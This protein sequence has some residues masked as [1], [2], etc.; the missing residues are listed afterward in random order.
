MGAHLVAT[1]PIQPEPWALQKL[2]IAVC[3]WFNG[4]WG[5]HKAVFHPL[6][7]KNGKILQFFFDIV[8][9]YNDEICYVKHALD[10]LCVFFTGPTA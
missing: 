7:V 8:T 9:T 2:Q 10:P 5:V 4:I 3:R 1:G 6:Q